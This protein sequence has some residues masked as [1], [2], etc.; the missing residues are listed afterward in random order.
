MVDTRCINT[1]Q[2][3]TNLNGKGKKSLRLEV[4]Y[5][6]HTE[7]YH[8]PTVSPVLHLYQVAICQG[9]QRI[10]GQTIVPKSKNKSKKRY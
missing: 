2:F 10:R 6:I 8:F 3:S 5:D 4:L 1:V 9:F 7:V